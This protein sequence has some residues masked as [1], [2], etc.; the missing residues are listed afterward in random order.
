MTEILYS[1]KNS[2]SDKGFHSFK[3]KSLA[4]DSII[5]KI[6]NQASLL[7]KKRVNI[8]NISEELDEKRKLRRY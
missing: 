5:K 3:K 4:A 8:K 1:L 6:I 2:S 7:K